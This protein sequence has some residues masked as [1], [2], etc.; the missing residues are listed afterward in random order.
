M[1]WRQNPQVHHS[2]HWSL[3]QAPIMSQLDP[4][5]TPQPISL[6]SILIPT[7]HLRL[8][9]LQVVSFLLA[10]PTKI[11]Y[12]FLYSPMRVTCPAHLIRLDMI[13]LIIFRDEYKIWSHSLCN[14][15][16]SPDSSSLFGLNILLRTLF[17]NTLSLCSPLKVRDQV[18]HPYR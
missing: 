16:H 2:I 18:S 17:S 5:Y 14:F 10:F 8:A 12:T 1:Q 15:L 6:R 3:P 13:C 7:S 4:L 11:M 9:R